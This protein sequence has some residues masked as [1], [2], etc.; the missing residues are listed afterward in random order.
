M[1]SSGA[2]YQRDVVFTESKRVVD[3][4]TVVAASWLVCHDVE[5]HL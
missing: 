5:V 3:G 1:A 2:K 4:V